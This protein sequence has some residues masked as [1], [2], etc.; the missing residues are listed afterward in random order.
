MG[1]TAA[2]GPPTGGTW[3]GGTNTG[4]TNTGGTTGSGEGGTAGEASGGTTGSGGEG[5]VASSDCPTA[6]GSMVLLPDGYCIDATEVT[7]SA[8]ES[9]R[10]SSGVLTDHANCSWKTSLNSA[11]D[12]PAQ[13]PATMLDWCDAVSFCDAVGK[14]LCG[15]IGGGPNVTADAFD[16][17]FDQWFNACSTGGAYEY[18][19]GDEF[20][21]GACNAASISSSSVAVASMSACQSP[22]PAYAD[23]YDL[24]GNVWEW[25]DVC[26]GSAQTS[27]CYI[28][29]GSWV[30]TGDTACGVSAQARSSRNVQTGFRCCAD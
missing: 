2:G 19:Y 17:E 26:L 7:R 15:R 4:G 21:S 10:T 9:W 11:G 22:D 8:Y 14:R 18:Q 29:G 23:V 28:R 5:G 30:S 3:T 16:P 13:N 25:Q 1:G 6:G 12:T 20:E 27:G 24:S